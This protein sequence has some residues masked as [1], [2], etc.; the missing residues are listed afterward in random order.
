MIKRI[1]DR[2]PLS[3]EVAPFSIIVEPD[4]L[5][6]KELVLL[7]FLSSGMPF[8]KVVLGKNISFSTIYPLKQVDIVTFWKIVKHRN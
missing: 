1:V 4:Q 8:T 2:T 7:E 3:S 6:V 5:S